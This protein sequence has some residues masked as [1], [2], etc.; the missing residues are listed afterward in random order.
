MLAGRLLGQS[1]R[2]EEKLSQKK[3]RVVYKRL[4]STG[5]LMRPGCQRS[6]AHQE[7]KPYSTESGSFVLSQC[8][9][10]WTDR[11]KSS[12]LLSRYALFFCRSG[13]PV[14]ASTALDLLGG[15]MKRILGICAVLIVLIGLTVPVVAQYADDNRR[16]GDRDDAG[17]QD[18][19]G[20]GHG[21]WRGRLSSE[22]QHRFDSYYSRWLEYRR[23]NNRDEVVSMEKRM[24]DVMSHNNIPSDVPFDQ[25]A[26]N[27]DRGDGGHYGQ[28]RGRLSSGDQQRFDSYYSRWLEYRRTNNRDEVVSMDKRMRDVM[29]RNNIPSDVPF[30]EIASGR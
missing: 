17:R 20:Y 13:L 28:R 6:S 24:R 30:V 7:G 4:N 22:D 15:F 23:S 11:I 14:N 21:Q 18:S 29:S 1:R 2:H 19:R 8:D 12:V 5:T 25:I 27:G 9:L 26:S 16:Q 3:E 10:F